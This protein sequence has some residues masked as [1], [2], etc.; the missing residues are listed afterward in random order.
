M[1]E[2]KFGNWQSRIQIF[3][4]SSCVRMTEVRMWFDR[5][6]KTKVKV[7]E[8]FQ[9]ESCV[10]GNHIYYM[11]VDSVVGGSTFCGFAVTIHF[12]ICFLKIIL[13]L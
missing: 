8:E 12:S 3:I 2:F 7:M 9:L 5:S 11:Y 10:Q 1:A 4:T 6:A 13:G